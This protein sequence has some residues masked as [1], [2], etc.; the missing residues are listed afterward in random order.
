MINHEE[1]I[2]IDIFSVKGRK[3]KKGAK[4]NNT[5][6]MSKAYSDELTKG[7]TEGAK[8]IKSY[9]EHVIDAYKKNQIINPKNEKDFA[10]KLLDVEQGVLISSISKAFKGDTIDKILNYIPQVLYEQN[11]RYSTQ[12]T[13]L[14][15]NSVQLKLPFEDNLENVFSE[16]TLKNMPVILY[17][18]NEWA[19]NIFGGK[20][21]N[22][23]KK[24]LDEHINK[25]KEFRVISP[26]HNG[27]INL[28]PLIYELP[29]HITKDGKIIRRLSLNSIF[30]LAIEKGTPKERFI[31][32]LSVAERSKYLTNKTDWRLSS[33]LESYYSASYYNI[34][35]GKISFKIGVNTIIEKIGTEIDKKHRHET[36][37]LTAISSSFYN[38]EQLGII[39]KGSFRREGD[40]YLWDWNKEY[41]ER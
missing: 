15:L 11:V 25:L 30:T 5:F 37:T 18:R 23:Q 2:K 33:L 21:Q 41:F 20:P 17:E 38:M 4:K 6:F 13:G 32:S 12:S 39:K 36:R 7:E 40:F 1:E 24:R 9:K 34:Q 14:A 31:K 10:S 26:A 8:L 19:K 28:L 22:S 29:E 35:S 3:K 16:R 27:G